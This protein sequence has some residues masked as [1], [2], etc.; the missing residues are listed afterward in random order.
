MIEVTVGRLD[1]GVVGRQP[2]VGVGAAV[3]LLDVRLEVVGVGDRSETWCQRGE[4]GDRHVVVVVADLDYDV[5]LCCNH[6]LRSRL[7]VW[8]RDRTLRVVVVCLVLGMPLV[9]DVVAIALFA[10]HDPMDAARGAI[11]AIV[12]EATSKLSL[13]VLTVALVDVAA[14]VATALVLVEVGA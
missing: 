4:G 6:D 11:L 5:V 7:T 10:L 13:L 3:V 8:V 12:V 9:L 1:S 2:D 14:S